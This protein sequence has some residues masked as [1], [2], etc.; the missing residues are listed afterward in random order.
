MS[1]P[2]YDANWESVD[3]TLHPSLT[4]HPDIRAFDEDGE[5]ENENE[6]KDSKEESDQVG[7]CV[8][9]CLRVCVC[10][11]LSVHLACH[12]QAY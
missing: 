6:N 4:P 10:E 1:N 3:K 11:L 9:A 2:L 8:C 12:P 7:C 5:N